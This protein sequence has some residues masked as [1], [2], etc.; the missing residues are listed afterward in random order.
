M[1]NSVLYPAS[2]GTFRRMVPP[3]SATICFTMDKPRPDPL[4][5]LLD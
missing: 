4:D 1:I 2:G 3:W 5:L